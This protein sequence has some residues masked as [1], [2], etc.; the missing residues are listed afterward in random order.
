LNRGN[1]AA[2]PQEQRLDKWLWH[3][4]LVKSRTL[5]AK[6]VEEGRVRV[7]RQRIVKASACVRCGDV[8]TATIHGRVRV[9]E[10]LA[11]GSRRGPPSEAQSLYAERPAP[12]A[13][14]A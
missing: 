13:D 12:S 14:P 11:I 8:L 9:I 1:G 3:A 5:A 10:V 2:P 4:R 6:L 7:N